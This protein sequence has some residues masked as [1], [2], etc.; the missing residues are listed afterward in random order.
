MGIE[1]DDE[2]A[3][4]AQ[5]FS[6]ATP[7]P[8]QAATEPEKPAQAEPEQ[9]PNP[10]PAATD[11]FAGLPQQVRDLL[12]NIPAL[13][14]RVQAAETN[15]RA[16]QG[17]VA[18]LQ[19]RFDKL[20][21]PKVEEAPGTQRSRFQ[22]VEAIRQELPEIA[23]AFDELTAAQPKEQPQPEVKP[24]PVQSDEQPS[25]PQIEFLNGE[26]PTW[27]DDVSSS[28]FQLWLAQQPPQYRQAVVNSDK[29]KDI[30]AALRQFDTYRSSLKSAQQ[31]NA[32]RSTRMAGA[33]T[34]QG[35][36]RRPERVMSDEDAE[37]AA[38]RAGF[39]GR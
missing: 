14:Q 22:A 17:R 19:S 3:A 31:T 29:A 23:A 25:D 27:G 1:A 9:P 16:A 38:F 21:Q 34:P 32:T 20:M 10:E 2:D 6:D 24:E 13:E 36:G 35:D 4:F 30:L 15:F 18:S 33:V 7:E 11:P 28:D 5:G 12:A 8:A 26:R 37:D 39:A